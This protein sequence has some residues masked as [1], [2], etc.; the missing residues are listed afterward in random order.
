MKC[1][2]CPYLKIRGSA[3]ITR[4]NRH[5]KGARSS[6]YCEHPRAEKI[7]VKMFPKS[8]KEPGFVSFTAPG[9]IT[10]MIK[11][12]PKWCPLKNLKVEEDEQ[13]PTKN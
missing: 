13:W 3:K 10:P 4:N 7:F 9:E 8:P 12:S 1:S 2:N 6:C 5:L 11:T